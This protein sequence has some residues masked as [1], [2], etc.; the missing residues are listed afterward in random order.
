MEASNEKKY[1][2]YGTEY[3][4]EE[5]WEGYRVITQL[6]DE[7]IEEAKSEMT[8]EELHEYMLDALSENND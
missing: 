7:D 3:T 4:V 6:D 1:D 5:L 8:D 2:L